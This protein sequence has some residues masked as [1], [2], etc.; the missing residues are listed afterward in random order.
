[1]KPTPFSVD[2][3]VRWHEEVCRKDRPL[4]GKLG[5]LREKMTAE[6]RPDLELLE[7]LLAYMFTYAKNECKRPSGHEASYQTPLSACLATAAQP[8][9]YDSLFKSVPSIVNKMWRKSTDEGP[10]VTLKNLASTITDLIRTDVCSETLD[11]AQFLALRMNDLPALLYDAQLKDQFNARIEAV[12]FEPEMK[13]ASGYFA[14]HGLVHFKSGYV[15]EVQIYSALMS[16][17]RK[18]SHLLYEQVRLAP[19]EQ[20]EFGSKESRLISLGHLLHLAE[21]EIQR[22]RQEMEGK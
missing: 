10:T 18:L 2:E 4:L 13:M 1:M 17:W 6:A 9:F 7:E 16:E 11:G 12:S 5:K 8:G 14:Y 15:V 19:I 22:L 20:H 21:C 3:Y